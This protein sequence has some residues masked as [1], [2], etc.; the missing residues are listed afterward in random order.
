L[1]AEEFV[2][3]SNTARNSL[4][5][6]GLQRMLDLADVATEFRTDS[7]KRAIDVAGGA[8]HSSRR[9]QGDKY[10]DQQVLDQSLTTLV[11]LKLLEQ[12]K[13]C[14]HTFLL[15]V[16]KS[17]PLYDLAFVY[18]FKHAEPYSSNGPDSSARPRTFI[19]GIN[20]LV[21]RPQQLS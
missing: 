5:I 18:R 17:Q 3:K 13:Q 16:A 15:N 1:G 2:K 21:Y 8:V 12:T 20:F 14:C 7:D 19:A 11:I 4:G 10:D 6:C 9:G